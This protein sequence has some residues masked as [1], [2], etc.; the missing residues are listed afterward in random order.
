[1][2]F[3]ILKETVIEN[4]LEMFYPDGALQQLAQQIVVSD[5][6]TK[7]CNAWKI[8]LE[9]A[10][11]LVKLALYD[12]WFLIDDSGSIKFSGLEGELKSLL[13]S[14]AFASSLFDQDGFSVRFLNSDVVGENIRTEQ[15]AEQLLDSVQYR[16]ITP[17]V[18]SLRDKILRPQLG[19]IHMR[20]TPRLKKPLL[21]IIITDGVPTDAPGRTFQDLIRDYK[22]KRTPYIPP[23][24]QILPPW[25]RLTFPSGCFPNCPGGHRQ[26]SPTLP[27]HARQG[28]GGGRSN[29]LYLQLRIGVRRVQG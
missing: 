1:M 2:I 12:I 24:P 15:Q 25:V 19:E 13:K 29:R 3:N 9:V 20:E 7:I 22:T 18:T 14:A 21:V 10:F 16:G 17:L 8:D 6:V 5:P 23:L 26:G 28:P 4:R 27:V 11:D